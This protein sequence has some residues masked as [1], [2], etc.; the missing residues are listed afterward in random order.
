MTDITKQALEMLITEASLQLN[1]SEEMF[2]HLLVSMMRGGNL[3]QQ[4][5]KSVI[6]DLYCFR[7]L[8]LYSFMIKNR[9]TDI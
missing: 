9:M 4:I 1:I 3:N 6:F 5:I 8:Y 2:E 7:V